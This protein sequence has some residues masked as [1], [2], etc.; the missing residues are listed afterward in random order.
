MAFKL[1]NNNYLVLK[2]AN[3]FQIDAI[4]YD[5]QYER[6]KEK[7]YLNDISQ[8]KER[9]DINKNTLEEFLSFFEKNKYIYSSESV[10]KENIEYIFMNNFSNIDICFLRYLLEPIKIKN[11]FSYTIREPLDNKNIYNVVREIFK[12]TGLPVIDC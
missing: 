1:S 7:K 3:N 4:I 11:K 5:S 8:L 2:K 9:E 12:E 6:E 10:I